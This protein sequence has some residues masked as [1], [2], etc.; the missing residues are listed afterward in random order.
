MQMPNVIISTDELIS[1]F[2]NRYHVARIGY[3][4]NKP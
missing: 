1:D 4:K 3:F 2:Q